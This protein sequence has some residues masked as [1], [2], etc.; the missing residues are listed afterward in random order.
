MVVIAVIINTPVKRESIVIENFNKYVENIPESEKIT[1][2]EGLYH[3]ATLNTDN[4]VKSETTASIREGT[5]RQSFDNN[6]YETYFIIDIEMLKQSYSV[7]NLYSNLSIEESGLTDYTLSILCLPIDDLKYGDFN[8]K[9]RLSQES[10]ISQSDPILKYLPYSTLDYTVTPIE[11]G[12]N[13]LI[14]NVDIL[15]SEADYKSDVEGIVESYGEEIEV[16]IESLDLNPD[17][18]NIRYRY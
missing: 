11:D 9:D 14:L 17:D 18:Y 15:I 8:C 10:N 4:K 7:S 16:W 12:G 2:E 5:Y 1:I 6:I 3:I 13:N